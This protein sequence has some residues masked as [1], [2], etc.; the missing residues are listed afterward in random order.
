MKNTITSY[1]VLIFLLI[2]NTTLLTGQSVFNL[3]GNVFY[4]EVTD[5]VNVNELNLENWIVA[6][7]SDTDTVYARTDENGNYFTG[8]NPAQ[9]GD[10]IDVVVSISPPSLYWDVCE[11]NVAVT[12]IEFTITTVDFAARSLVDCSIIDAFISAVG[13]RPCE[14]NVFV[15]DYCNHGT[16]PIEDATFE[17]TLDDDLSYV[18]SPIPPSMIDGQTIT[19]E[20][21]TLPSNSCGQIPIV[22]FTD[23]DSVAID[24]ILCLDLRITPDTVCLAAIQATSW[25]GALLELDY[26]C[27]NDN[28]TFNITNT[29]TG[30]MTNALDYII[31]EDAILREQNN[32]NLLPGETFDTPELPVNGATYHILAPQEPG[33]PGVPLLS[34][35]TMNCMNGPGDLNNQ[36]SQNN[37]DPFHIT[38]CPVVVGSYDPNDKTAYP[39][40]LTEEHIIPSNTELQYTIRFQN[41]GTDTAFSVVLLDTLSSLLN[42][43]TI[44]TGASSHPYTWDLTE[45][46]ILTFNFT[47]IALPDSLTN[48]AGSQ[49]YVTF[50][51]D[52]QRNL[53]GGTIIENTA[54]IYFDFNAPIITN[55]VFHTIFDDLEIVTGTI[56]TAAPETA[57]TLFPN[58]MKDGAWLNIEGVD[59]ATEP[60]VVT[61]YDA[62]GRIV[63][64]VSGN[65]RVW[66]PRK[67]LTPGMYFFTITNAQGWLASGKLM[68]E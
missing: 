4:D 50:T 32:F 3:E 62:T 25:S 36:I 33:A 7:M 60:M 61:L 35:S 55:T 68:V 24:D 11:N 2:L 42:P 59:L 45:R 27:D 40:G 16:I 21:G 20:V 66:L 43:A 31:I 19:W 23:C 49:G 29:G 30:S 48:P 12:L 34:I 56:Q 53:T 67:N 1:G 37:G 9:T 38:F 14:D 52:Q 8:L 17:L 44:I 51:I 18:S 6:V 46:G 13:V 22:A 28:L 54:A 26:T 41:T 15:I 5:C 58:P 47:D 57:V 65:D 63:Y 10:S 64:S 39:A